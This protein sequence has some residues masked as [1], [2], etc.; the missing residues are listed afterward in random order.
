MTC[1]LWCWYLYSIASR[2]YGILGRPVRLQCADAIVNGREEL[3][4]WSG[5]QDKLVLLL[6]R[7]VYVD[8]VL[9]NPTYYD[10]LAD[11][12]AELSMDGSLTIHRYEYGDNARYWCKSEYRWLGMDLSSFGMYIL[13]I[14]DITFKVSI[15]LISQLFT[16]ST[17]ARKIFLTWCT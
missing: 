12:R 13:W 8:G 15:Y 3:E 16:V 14:V 7:G 1:Y 2:V 11:G 4:W 6:A 5:Y 9:T 17:T 10:R